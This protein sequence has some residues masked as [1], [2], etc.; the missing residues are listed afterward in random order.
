M[1]RE[2]ICFSFAPICMHIHHEQP[3][4]EDVLLIVMLLCFSDFFCLFC[5]LLTFDARNGVILIPV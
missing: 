4:I 1:R 3:L 2:A 5:Q